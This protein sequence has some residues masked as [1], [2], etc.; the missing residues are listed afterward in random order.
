MGRAT[1][2]A[3]PCRQC[4]CNNNVDPNAI[5][6]CNRTTGECIR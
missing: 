2:E 5:G 6:N 1:G 4:Q 3:R